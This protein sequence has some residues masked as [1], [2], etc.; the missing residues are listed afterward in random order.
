MNE[1][2]KPIGVFDSGLGGLT[3]VKKIMEY[4]PHEDIV[5]F[6]DTARVPYGNRS[7]ETI[8]RYTRQ[9]MEFLLSRDVKAV[10]IACN[11]A[12]SMARREMEALFDVPIVGAVA[13]AAKKA[14]AVTRNGKIGVLGTFATVA[15]G[16]YTKEIAACR[17]E[18]RVFSVASPLLVPLVEA[19]RFRPGDAVTES[20]LDDYLQPLREKEIDTIILGCTHYPLLYDIVEALM[21]GVRIICSGFASAETLADLLTE[22]DLRNPAQTPGK[23]SFFVSDAPEKFAQNGSVFLGRE[24]AGTVEK[25]PWE[26]FGQ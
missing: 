19:G 15:S 23:T 18:C 9:D 25:I 11:T 1:K 12:D 20:V 4:L 7:R 13:P 16:A 14:A 3:A 22:R 10:C 5:Y 26:Q 2:Q 21:P 24:I 8:V 17:P 6:G